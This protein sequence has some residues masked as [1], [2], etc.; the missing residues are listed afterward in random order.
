MDQEVTVRLPAE[1]LSYID[2]YRA[3]HGLSTRGEVLTLALELLRERELLEGYRALAEEMAQQADK[4]VASDSS[5]TT[6][7][8]GDKNK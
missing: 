4:S 2:K 5:E 1:T 7:L 8:M 6:N 3:S